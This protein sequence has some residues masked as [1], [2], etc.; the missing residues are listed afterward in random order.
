MAAPRPLAPLLAGAFAVTGLA[1]AYAHMT[2]PVLAHGLESKTASVLARDGQ[3]PVTARFVSGRRWPSRH[4]VLTGGETLAPDTRAAIARA[5]AQVPGVG[6]VIWADSPLLDRARAA[7]VPVPQCQGDVQ[8]LLQART[9]RFAEG[10]AAIL[11]GSQVLLDEVA[12]ALRPCAGG[13]VAVLGHSDRGGDEAENLALS[14]ARAR[15]VRAALVQRGIPPGDLRA[16]GMGSAEPLP[17]LDP[18][19]PA[20][21]RITFRVIATRPLVPTPVDL[22]GAS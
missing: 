21:R 13:Q 2:G 12:E 9:I 6:G 15:A 11:P 16:R 1:A 4:P 18:T 20:N 8:A 10:S 14:R 7:P 5:V 17:R 19:D 22:P 3:P